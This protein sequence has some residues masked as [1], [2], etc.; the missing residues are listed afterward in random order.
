MNRG[1]I[2]RRAALAVIRAG[3]LVLAVF[4]L[5]LLGRGAGNAFAQGDCGY[6][7]LLAVAWVCAIWGSVHE[8]LR[9]RRALL[10]ARFEWSDAR[11]AA[12]VSPGP[13]CSSAWS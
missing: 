4:A 5:W 10:E 8:G 2:E 7:G 3:G 1:E 6:G 11:C 12:A 9:S 13:A